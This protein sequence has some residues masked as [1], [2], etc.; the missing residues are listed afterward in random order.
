MCVASSA[1]VTFNGNSNI[2]IS[3]T[4]P[5]NTG[6]SIYS[7]SSNLKFSVCHPGNT[8]SPKSYSGDITIDKDLEKCAAT[9]CTTI[10]YKA[11]TA[12]VTCTSMTDSQLVGNCDTGYWKDTTGTADVCRPH[13]VCGNQLI[14]SATRL[15]G[16]S[17]TAAGTCNSCAAYTYAKDNVSNCVANIC[18]C[19]FG[20]PT[21][22]DGTNETLCEADSTV[23]CSECSAGYSMSAAAAVGLQYCSANSCS[24]TQVLNSDKSAGNSITGMLYVYLLSLCFF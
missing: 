21:I 16:A 11:T 13:T 7:E 5:S 19:P 15:T 14:G 18:T 6:K 22:F 1:S 2:M 24:A 20:T 8:N 10:D 3:N 4:A 9:A 12:T 17:L 23:D